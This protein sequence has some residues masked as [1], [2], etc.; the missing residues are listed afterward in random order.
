MKIGVFIIILRLIEL[1]KT[2]N[3]VFLKK[4]ND[5]DTASFTGFIKTLCIIVL[6]YYAFK[7]AMRYL[8]PILLI[9]VVKKAGANFQQQQ[10]Q[11]YNQNNSYSSNTSTS[12]NT[13]KQTNE[14]PKSTKIV[15]EYIEFEEID[16][17]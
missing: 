2:N 4:T 5:M 10:Q 14:V 15:G 11:Y 8:L 1:L 7:F 16:S 3:L 17:K 9:K 13:S 6:V 12:E